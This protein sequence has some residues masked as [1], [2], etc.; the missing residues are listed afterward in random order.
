MQALD[1]AVVVFDLDDTLYPE[2][3]YQRSGVRYLTALAEELSGL[4]IND[5]V[6]LAFEDNPRGDF[7]QH[8][9]ELTGWPP[10]VKDSLLWAYRLHNP[11]ISLSSETGQFLDLMRNTCHALAVLTDGRVAT[12]TAKI[13]ALQIEWMPAFIS[14]AW[15]SPKPQNERFIEIERRWPDKSYF[16]IGDNPAKDFVAPNG[17]GWVTIGLIGADKNVHSQTLSPELDTSTYM[18]IHWVTKLSDVCEILQ[19]MCR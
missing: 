14:E 13:R 8:I 18:P 12:Q 11:D 7:I 16:Y 9:C 19:R 3:D 10:S 4:S 2:V 15:D 17:L 1:N 6:V 5:E